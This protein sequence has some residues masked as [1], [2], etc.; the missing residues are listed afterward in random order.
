MSRRAW[1][2]LNKDRHRRS[3]TR[4]RVTA[5][6]PLENFTNFRSWREAESSICIQEGPPLLNF[7]IDS[8]TYPSFPHFKGLVQLS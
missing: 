2:S 1:S 7:P 5:S 8:A 4:D 3:A 6:K